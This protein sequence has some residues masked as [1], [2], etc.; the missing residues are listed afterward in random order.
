MRRSFALLF[1]LFPTVL[2]AVEPAPKTVAAGAKLVEVY[3][4]DR[5]FEGPTWDPAGMKLYFTSASKDNF[6]ILR[7]DAPGKVSVFA[8]KTDG[9]IGT[10]LGLDGQLLGAQSV[11]HR[12]VAYKLKTG[13]ME[14]LLQDA[15]LNQPNDLCQAPNG[16]IYF[17]DPDFHRISVSRVYLW[18]KGMTRPKRLDVFSPLP[19]GIKTSLDGKTLYVSDSQQ[20]LWRA[21]PILADG[22]VGDGRVL[23]NPETENRDE[24]DGLTLDEHGNLYLTGRGG[25]WVVTPEGKPLGL[26]A[27]KEFCSNLTF[28]G[29]DFDVLYITCAKKVYSLK[30]AVK[31]GRMAAKK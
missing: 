6:Q 10:T 5:H 4:A 15:Q 19:N 3:A 25:V 12:L 30:M 23:F 28:G 22:S 24:P 13:E 11:G 20:R 18:R 29:D 7:L 26:I 14:V 2:A 16:D 1:A 21:F 8:D 31:G 9:V 17:S 27:V